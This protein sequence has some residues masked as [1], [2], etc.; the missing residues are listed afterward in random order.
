M[1]DIYEL[2]NEA[3]IHLDEFEENML[4]EVY[5]K[6]IKKRARGQIENRKNPF[7]QSSKIAIVLL[8][9]LFSTTFISFKINPTFATS[10]PVFGSIIKE[11]SGY[12]NDLFD[13]Y[14][15]VINKSV[16][17]DGI[18][19]TL[20]EVMLDSN[21]L[22]IATTINIE[23]AY[24]E[25]FYPAMP[26]VFINGNILRSRGGSGTG[27]YIE[28]GTLVNISM[29]E[30]HDT[31]IPS[32]I[33]MK[34]MYENF[35][36]LDKKGENKMIKGPW[37]FDFAISKAAIESKTETYKLKR[38]VVY[39]DVE[40]YLK[41]ITITPLTTHLK[42]TFRGKRP[43]NFLIMDEKGNALIEEMSGFGTGHLLDILFRKTRGEV[44]FSA[45]PEG[46]KTLTVI[47]YYENRGIDQDEIRTI[48]IKFEGK[49]PLE[50][51]QDDQNKIII[52]HVERRA[53]KVYVDFK[54][55]G[56]SYQIQEY[57]LYLYGDQNERLEGIADDESRYNVEGSADMLTA[58]FE[59]HPES[60]LYFGT[61][62][63]ADIDIIEGAAF[64]IDLSD[65]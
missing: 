4:D 53:D 62:T 58:V 23:N 47:P 30:V 65:R 28:P 26:T 52:Y 8:C 5:R 46:S 54:T 31:K 33:N 22:R 13:Q 39:N 60:A 50:L 44:N 43:I 64:T 6:K 49:L 38:K 18:K 35:S 59:D 27:E 3:D 63:M 10:I 12:G 42:Y 2:L 16:E 29:I 34:I 37:V 9:I 15:A 20:N 7:V 1:K 48:P 45:V 56:I 24:E 11:I 41:D 32:N 19:I 40:M 14:T 25:N 61:D 17:K 57:R 36:Y 21:Q 51:E 55:E